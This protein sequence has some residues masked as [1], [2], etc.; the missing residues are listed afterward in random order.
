MSSTALK[1]L[2]AIALC[3]FSPQAFTQDDGPAIPAEK[4]QE[5]KAQKS[6]YITQ[7][8]NL[9]TEEARIFW[10]IYDKYQAEIE[11]SRGKERA[12]RRE[13]RA[14]TV[15]T[16]EQASKAIADEL[17]AEQMQLDL[18]K[19]YAEQFKQAI[20]PVKTLK[21]GEAERSF[22]RELLKRIRNRAP[23]VGTP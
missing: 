13:R 1:P 4:L 2:L 10:P 14:L 8:L 7:Q 9:T 17:Q 22:N 18:R 20:G 16:D 3:L 21:L 11:A 15:L 19:R 5:I 12:L 6:A 23:A